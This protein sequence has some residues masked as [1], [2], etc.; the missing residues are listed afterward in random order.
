MKNQTASIFWTTI[1]ITFVLLIHNGTEPLFI[2][3]YAFLAVLIALFLFKQ[4]LWPFVIYLFIFGAFGRYTRYVRQT[5]ASDTLLAIRDYIGYFLAGKNVY[6]QIIWAQSGLTP[7]TYLPFGL[8]WYLPAQILTIDLRFFEM[9]ISAFVPLEIFLYGRLKKNWNILPVFAVV[10]LT[11]FLLDLSADGS[12]DNSAIFLLLLSLLFFL[13]SVDRK[14]AKWA[15]GSAVVLGFALTFKHYLAFFA[16]FFVPFLWQAKQFLPISHKKYLLYSALTMGLVSLPFI[17]ASPIGFWKSLFFIEIGNF[18]TT[19]GWNIWVALRDSWGLVF[20]KQQMWLVRTIGTGALALGLFKFFRL[21][22]L[23]RVCIASGLT[24][25]VYL[26]L[27]NWTTYAYFSFLVPLFA[28][29]AITSNHNAK[30]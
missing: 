28:L 30:D 21:Q 9:I 1:T 19:W 16:I 11:P 18:H 24:M 14:S 15:I 6:Q 10:A 7:F 5:Y 4:N 8:F 29:A 2:A 13:Q 3:A 25:L 17:I 27:S 22:N 26:I 12:N 20:T 23:T